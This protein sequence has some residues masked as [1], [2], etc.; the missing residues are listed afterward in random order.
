MC[1]LA[2]LDSLDPPFPQHGV[3]EHLLRRVHPV[4]F[5]VVTGDGGLLSGGGQVEGLVWRWHLVWGRHLHGE[6]S[7]ENSSSRSQH[8]DASGAAALPRRSL[9]LSNTPGRL[10]SPCLQ[11]QCHCCLLQPSWDNRQTRRPGA[12]GPDPPPLPC[13]WGILT[14]EILQEATSAS[15]S[16][17]SIVVGEQ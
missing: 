6:A 8:W 5:S 11:G 9:L 15:Q 4:L 2:V 13:A 3:P 12:G 1:A 17:Q 7:D 10:H 14:V 16:P